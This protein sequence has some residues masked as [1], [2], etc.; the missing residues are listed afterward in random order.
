MQ[1]IFATHNPNK[2]AEVRAALN[3]EVGILS[4][5]DLGDRDPIAEPFFTLEENA[6]EKVKVVYKRYGKPAFAEDTGLEIA[7]LEGRPGVLSARYASAEADMEA[8]IAKV[9]REMKERRPREARFRTVFALIWGDQLHFFEG[10]IAGHLATEKIGQGG[11]G[12]DSVFIPAGYEESFAQLGLEIKKKIS[13]RTVA[14]QKMINFIR[15]K[16]KYMS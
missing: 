2:V 12:Y 5:A 14:F 7:A 9:L 13:H 1:L 16:R 10:E 8:N 6:A 15:E 11:F 4:L 3:G